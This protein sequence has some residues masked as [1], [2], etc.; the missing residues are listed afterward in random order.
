[1]DQKWSFLGLHF[2][3]LAHQCMNYSFFFSCLAPYQPKLWIC[4]CWKQKLIRK[5]IFI[6]ILRPLKILLSSIKFFQ[7]VRS[8]ASRSRSSSFCC[9][10]ETLRDNFWY[11]VGASCFASSSSSL[12]RKSSLNNWYSS[13]SSN[14][15]SSSSSTSASTS[16]NECLERLV[17]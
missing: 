10:L 5:G 12:A 6:L 13:S 8:S 14:S 11:E 15:S 3:I 2:K 7:V 17:G 4:R 9:C 16:M 1:M